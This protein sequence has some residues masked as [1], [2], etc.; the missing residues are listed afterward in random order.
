MITLAF[1][2]SYIAEAAILFQYSNTIFQSKTTLLRN[3]VA[4]LFCYSAA[5]FCSFAHI[6]TL[7]SIVFFLVSGIYLFCCYKLEW[8]AAAFHALLCTAF[9]TLS[10]LLCS[11]LLAQLTYNYWTDGILLS[12]RLLFFVLSKLL[13]FFCLTIVS[14]LMLKGKTPSGIH[15]QGTLL[16]TLTGI[17][18]YF[19]CITFCDIVESVKLSPFLDTLVSISAILMLLL[20]FLVL[21]FYNDLQKKHEQYLELC[22]QRQKESAYAEYQKAVLKQDE[23]QKIL[24][25]D[26]RKHLQAIAALNAD[27][28]SKEVASY[29][30]H[31]Y[32]SSNLRTAVRVCDNELLNCILARYASQ[33]A[34]NH[35]ELRTDIRSRSINFIT[36]DEL[37]GI[38]C[39][40]LDN[41]I[42]AAEAF[43]HSYI[44][45]S[46]S[47]RQKISMTVI[48]LINSC[49]RNPFNSAGQLVTTKSEDGFHGYGL[50]S[51]ERIAARYQGDLEVYYAEPTHTFHTIITLKG[52]PRFNP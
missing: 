44:E 11:M 33:C 2:A 8:Y 6:T 25:H 10:E 43:P 42:R 29:I 23:N 51:V 40:I 14:R 49:G 47:Y 21:W 28:G 22:L 3:L 20:N 37:T 52:V 48:S 19:A 12:Q 1:F 7:N 4:L 16:L 9:M 39:N 13:Y 26:I 32:E 46:V 15:N 18:S 36:D 50:K 31:L 41:A 45:L 17:F 34:Q 30:E 27:G 5:F 38:F 35:I 24:I